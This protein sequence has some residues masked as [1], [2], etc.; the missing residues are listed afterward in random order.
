MNVPRRLSVWE[1]AK[2]DPIRAQWLTVLT[3]MDALAG[4]I[5]VFVPAGEASPILLYV[6]GGLLLAAAVLVV[7]GFSVTGGIAGSFGWGVLVATVLFAIVEWTALWCLAP[8]V[9]GWAA[10]CHVLIVYEVG[11]RLDRDRERRQRR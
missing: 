1:S 6:A 4:A 3:V 10:A 9:F 5:C 11:S 8:V 7:V 2:S